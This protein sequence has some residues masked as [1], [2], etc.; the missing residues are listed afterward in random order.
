MPPKKVQLSISKYFTASKKKDGINHSLISPKN[1]DLG[2][3]KEANEERIASKDQEAGNDEK[4]ENLVE[5][6]DLVDSKAHKTPVNKNKRKSSNDGKNQKKAKSNYTPLESQIIQFK[7]DNKDKMLLFQVGYKY[8][9]YGEDAKAGSEILNIMYVEDKKNDIFS[10]CSFPIFKLH[11]NLKRLLNFGYKIGVVK[12]VESAIIKSVEKTT[13]ADVMRR[14]IEGIY[15]KGTYMNDEFLESGNNISIFEEENQNYIVCVNDTKPKKSYIVAIQPLTGDIVY[16]EFTD[17]TKKQELEIRLH[18]LNPSEIVII[19]NEDSIMINTMK[20]VRSVCGDVQ[21]IHSK[22]KNQD[23]VL[24]ELHQ[25]FS[26]IKNGEY[27]HLSQ[28]YEDRF[29]PDILCCVNELILY[30]NEFKLSGSFL[31]PENISNFKQSNKHMVLQSN[32]IKELEIFRNSTDP[33]VLKGSLAW[34]LNKSKTRFGNRLLNKWI[35]RPLIQ[36]ALIEERSSAV[37]DI[38]KEYNHF[39]ECIENQLQKIGNK[40]DLEEILIKIHYSAT[41]GSGKVSRKELYLFLECFD[42]LSSMIKPFEETIEN[43]NKQAKSPLLRGIFENL[44]KINDN[45][46]P[47]KFLKMINPS[48][49]LNEAGDINKQKVQFFDLN[50]HPWENIINEKKEIENIEA[51]LDEELEKIKQ[52]LKRPQL[53]YIT[54]KN[55][56]FLIEVRNTQVDSLPNDW[57]KIGGTTTVSRFRTPRISELYKLHQYHTEMLY[58]SSDSAYQEFLSMVNLEYNFFH[59]IINDLAVI[60]CILALKS[61]SEL[62]GNY[63]KPHLTDEQ[64]INVTKSRNPIIENLPHTNTYVENDVNISYDRDRVIIITGPNMG[65]KS[66]YVKQVALLVIMAQIGCYLPCESATIGIFDSIFVR[67]GAS[68]NILKGESTFMTELLE[69]SNILKNMTG[70]SLIILDEIGRG[71]G[72]NDGIAIA[73]SILRYLIEIPLKPLT[74]FITH[75]PSLHILEDS[76]KGIVKNYHMGYKKILKSKSEFD[77]IIFLYTLVRGVASSLYGLNVAKLAGLPDTVINRAFEVSENL[78]DEIEQSNIQKFSLLFCKIIKSLTENKN[79]DII[80][81]DKLNTYI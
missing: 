55:E 18:Y 74:L 45:N 51:Q 30:L 22:T 41:Y 58:L 29:T 62:Q 23:M 14:E 21:M 52:Y 80:E 66:S 37:E 28:V 59:K 40:Y 36:K 77:E 34:L 10:Y 60:D 72:T 43:F 24:Q 65:G 26:T 57:Q 4:E 33:T 31:I 32:V 49:I 35:S 53:K 39:I 5:T 73:Y 47:S 1:V 38:K 76:N 48:Y 46:I 75:Y 61:V 44:I 64:V 11:I 69:C 68:D 27:Q 67:M 12:Q 50:Y 2:K 25:F 16:D 79:V 7:S 20:I 9:L 6:I 13:N 56:P 63:I 17:D 15:T 78:K 71:T 3:N 81:I 42:N 8:K 70:K 19:N 54:I